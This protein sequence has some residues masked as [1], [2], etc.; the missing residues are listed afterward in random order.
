MQRHVTYSTINVLGL[1][2]GF[3]ASFFILIWVQDELKYDQQY[4]GV[5]DVY[6]LMRTSTYGPD[7]IYTWPAVTAKLD[8]VL[9]EEYPEIESVALVS[10]QQDM[11]FSR[12]DIR[13]RETGRHA[14][15]DF[16]EILKHDFLSGIS[17]T[18][19]DLSDSV[20]LSNEMARKYFPAIYTGD[21][22]DDVGAALVLGQTLTLDNR[23]EVTVTGVVR[24][25]QQQ[26][27]FQFDF[28]LP[29]EEFISRNGWVDDW[30]NSG[31]KL[32]ARL[33]PGADYRIVSEKIR[34]IIQENTESDSDIL[35]LQPYT[36]IY[37]KS[38]YESGILTGGRIETLNIFSM[39]GIFILFIA[40]INFMNLATARSAQRAL[41][42]SIRKTFGSSRM[43]L[44]GQFIGEAVLTSV[45]AL[46]LAG[47]AVML[48][49]PGFNALTEKEITYR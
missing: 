17:K 12:D 40:A 9:D 47:V 14:G 22:S 6:R 8:D 4:E 11:S 35:F 13:F 34:L 19:L 15:Q 30:G 5:E 45:L 10:W 49:L 42:V 46:V 25:I 16:F 43:H 7:Q 18:A 26:A 48:L 38:N 41:E 3:L 31:L 27:S 21:V 33:T 23:M 1:G 39:V 37:L 20:V 44:A 2:I 29:I 36:D 28:V 32:F 24:D